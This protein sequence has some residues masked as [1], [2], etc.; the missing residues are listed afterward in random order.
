MC[1][2]GAADGSTNHKPTCMT[3]TAL[4]SRLLTRYRLIGPRGGPHSLALAGY[5]SNRNDLTYYQAQSRTKPSR[6]MGD[7]EESSMH[8]KLRHL[9]WVVSFTPSTALPAGIRHSRCLGPKGGLNA[10]V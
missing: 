7:W 6:R 1:K 8:C 9:S 3:Q 2:G 4:T 10:L 5:T